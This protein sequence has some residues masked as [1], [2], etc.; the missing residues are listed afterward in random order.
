MQTL[1]RSRL[2]VPVQ[3]LIRYVLRVPFQILNRSRPK[4]LVQTLNHSRSRLQVHM[5]TLIIPVS[6]FPC[7]PY[8]LPFPVS[9]ANLKP[10]LSPGSRENRKPFPSL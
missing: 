2:K 1:N 5:K 4:V 9:R 10:F 7:K 3:T 6:W 8:T